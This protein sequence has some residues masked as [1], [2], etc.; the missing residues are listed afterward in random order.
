MLDVE[1]VSDN[2]L[3]QP[4]LLGDAGAE[5]L[6][7]LGWLPPGHNSTNWT[8]TIPVGDKDSFFRVA[9]FFI[10][11]PRS[12]YSFVGEEVDIELAD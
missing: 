4:N 7:A 1:A 2:Y 8:R 11:T 9:G 6:Q 12:V 3:E 5:R 10:E